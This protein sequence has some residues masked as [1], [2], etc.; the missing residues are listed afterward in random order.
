MDSTLLT[1]SGPSGA[2]T[3]SGERIAMVLLVIWT[4]YGRDVS[5]DGLGGGAKLADRRA[6][7]DCG[8]HRRDGCDGDRT[9]KTEYFASFRK[10]VHRSPVNRVYCF[11]LQY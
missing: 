10:I 1:A 8:A 11:R 7:L 3:P 5:T 4:G 2:I 9:L 6:E